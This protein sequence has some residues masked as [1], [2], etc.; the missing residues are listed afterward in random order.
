MFYRFLPAV[1]AV[2]LLP[3]TLKGQLAGKV[4]NEKGES[5][6]G[7]TVW[8]ESPQKGT[9]SNEDGS[10]ILSELRKWPEM[11]RFSHVG[12][13]P[14]DTLIASPDEPL[15]LVMKQRLLYSPEVVVTAIRSGDNDP[16]TVSELTSDE[17]LSHNRVKDLPYL[18]SKVPSVVITSDGG[19]GVGYSGLRIRGSDPSRI[20]VTIDGIPFN[21]SESHDVYWVD[22]PD[23]VSSVDEIQIQRGVGTSTL[24]AAAFGANIHIR[25]STGQ[26][27]PYA[28][29]QSSAGS[30]NTMKASVSAGTGLLNNRYQIN[31]RTS[32]IHTDG[33]IDRAFADLSSG[34]LSGSLNTG[35]GVLKFTLLNGHERTYQAWGGVPLELLETNR[36]YN[37]YEY[38]NEVDDYTQ[39]HLH[40]H[41]SHHFTPSLSLNSSLHYTR[42][43]GYYEQFREDQ[44]LNDYLMPN[45]LFGDSTLESSDLVRQKWLDNHFGGAIMN[46]SYKKNKISLQSGAGMNMY[47]GDHFG[48]VVWAEYY[49]LSDPGHKYYA[50][51]GTKKE[52]NI[53]AKLNWQ[54][55][56]PLFIYLDL[57]YRAIDY[58]IQGKDDDQRDISQHHFYPFFNPKAGLTLRVNENQRWYGSFGVANREPKRSNFTDAAPGQT[59]LPERLFDLESGYALQFETF[60]ADVNVYYM[61]YRDQLIHTG[62]INDVG[63]PVMV[64]VPQSYR[65]GIEAAL[66]WAPIS[67]LNI[68]LNVTVSRNKILNHTEFVDDWDTWTQ[69]SFYLGTSDL[70][71]SP[72]LTGASGVSLF[73]LK[74]LTLRWDS[75]YV[76]KQ[77]IDNTSSDERSIDPYWV[78]NLHVS[79]NV[80]LKSARQLRIFVDVFNAFNAMYESSAWVYSYI[81]EGS[82]YTMDGYFP[83]AGRHFLAGLVLSLE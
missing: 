31:F 16:V 25:S 27:N 5:I 32:R 58:V 74:G 40:L 51:T 36:T 9:I 71:F 10:W 3:L 46:V 6:E 69:Q 77:Y 21:D 4:I 20:N 54:V 61:R 64:N 30:F 62:Q 66:V 29:I 48:K 78:N 13:H 75:Q 39:N 44:A 1:L 45:L 19:T 15:I 8:A 73:P 56:E 22:I 18:L 17:M 38:E 65:Q 41:Y 70:A 50:S 24:G 49:T 26:T 34:Y 57:Q 79:Y 59:V 37:P 63:A 23:V 80:G 68:D 28:E 12:Y 82:R 76:G 55:L 72:A 14:I 7:V 11:I 60:N 35:K 52:F 67:F 53:F 42:G 83:Q 47:F 33:F 43:Y 2:A 81:Y